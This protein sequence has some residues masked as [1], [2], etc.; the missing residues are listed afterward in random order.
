MTNC[1]IKVVFNTYL[2]VIIKTVNIDKQLTV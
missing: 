2:T 1:T